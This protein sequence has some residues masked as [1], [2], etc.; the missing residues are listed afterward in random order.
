MVLELKDKLA[1]VDVA[2]KAAAA[3][4]SGPDYNSLDKDVLSALLNLGCACPAAEEAIR[5]VKEKGQP[6]AFEAYFRA[7]LALVR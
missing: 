1:G 6:A 5:K 7:A 2:G 4:G 3:A